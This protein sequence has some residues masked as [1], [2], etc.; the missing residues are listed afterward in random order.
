[1]ESLYGLP[2]IGDFV[3]SQKKTLEID[4]TTHI[5]FKVRKHTGLLNPG[6]DDACWE[7]LII[8]AAEHPEALFREE[9][10]Y[11]EWLYQRYKS[12]SINR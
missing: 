3:F 7:I 9:G 2:G 1:M 5:A 11:S 12:W 8:S 10:N 4:G 6:P